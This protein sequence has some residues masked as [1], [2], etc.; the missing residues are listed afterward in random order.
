MG[1]FQESNRNI[2]EA[3]GF[4]GLLRGDAKGV[5]V[6]DFFSLSKSYMAR[7]NENPAVLC[8]QETSPA[9]PHAHAQKKKKTRLE[10]S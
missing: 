10:R 8:T 7:R 5:Q 2:Y 1:Y 3:V 6:L 9:Q 4:E